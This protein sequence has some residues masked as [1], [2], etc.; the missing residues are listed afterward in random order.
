MYIYIRILYIYIPYI[1]IYTCIFIYNLGFSLDQLEDTPT[2]DENFPPVQ[3]GE[4]IGTIGVSPCSRYV[5][6]A[7]K[8]PLP[9][10]NNT[11]MK[12]LILNF[13]GDLVSPAGDML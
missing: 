1:H 6:V 11:G 7:S 8:Y 3:R 12:C 10:R 9:L 2:S 4:E 13:T 5:I